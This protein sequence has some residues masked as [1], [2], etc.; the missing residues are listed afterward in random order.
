MRRSPDAAAGGNKQTPLTAAAG[1]SRSQGHASL[2]LTLR[3]LTIRRSSDGGHA[4]S[5]GV[6]VPLPLATDVPAYLEKHRAPIARIGM[7]PESFAAAYCVAVRVTPIG[8]RG[9]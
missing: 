4:I 2:N 3:A 7:T 8:V 6:A 1:R 5:R 9:H